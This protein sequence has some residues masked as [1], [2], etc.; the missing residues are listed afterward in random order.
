MAD[1][2]EKFGVK[3][4]IISAVDLIQGMGKCAGLRVIQ[5]PGA[6]G[7]CRTD[8]AAKGRAAIEALKQ[9]DFVYIHVEAPDECGHHGNA[10]EKVKSIEEIDGKIVLPVMEF[11]KSC[12]EP[13]GALV[14]PDHPTLVSTTTHSPAPV[15]FALYDSRRAIDNGSGI[16]FTEPCAQSTGLYEEH[17]HELM[18]LMVNMEEISALSLHKYAF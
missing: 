8:Y 12:G 3:G 2:E 16:R 15:P 5:V 11:L 17:A 6:T 1:F 13:F 7:D 18:N 14:M 4:S 9:D 10:A